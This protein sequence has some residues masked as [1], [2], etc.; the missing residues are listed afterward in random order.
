MNSINK[1]K[2]ESSIRN[3]FKNLSKMKELIQN[4]PSKLTNLASMLALFV[5]LAWTQTSTAQVNCNVTMACNDGVQ[6]SL[7]ENCLATI[8]PD[9]ILENPQFDMDDYAVLIYDEAGDLVP[10][11]TLDFSHV[12]Q[13]FSV[14]VQLIGCAAACWGNITLEDK[15]PPV[16]NDCEDI[17]VECGA[18]LEPGSP[19]VPFPNIV[20]ACDTN[21]DLVHFDEM[22]TNACA[23][24][25]VQTITRTWVATDGSGNE[26]TCVQL[27]QVMKADIGN[28]VFPPNFDDVDQPSFSCGT[29]IELLDNGAPSP[30]V[31][32]FPSGA[33]CP[34]IQ[35]F[36]EDIIFDICGASIKILRAWVVIDWCTGEERLENQII[37]I[38]DDQ[39]PV[40]TAA[41][42]F[43]FEIPTDQGL[44][45]GTFEVPAPTV[46]FE[47]SD[48][49]YTVGYRLRADGD[50]PFTDLLFDNITRDSGTGLFT[51]TGLPQDTSWIVYTLTDACGNVSQCF[52][53]VFIQDDESPTPV[54]EGF[55]VV[56]LE[57][58]GWADIFAS[59]IDDGSFDNC[60]I[61]RFEVRRLSTPCGISSDLNFGDRVNFCC[62][63]VADGPV[64]VV[65]RVYDVAGN[66]NDCIV[67]VTVQDKIDP[68][69]S[70]PPN[71]SLQC[72]ADFTNLDLTGRATATDNCNVTLEYTDTENINECGLGS[73]S[74]RWVATDP[75]G[76]SVNCTQIITLVDNDPFGM[77][78]ITFPGDRTIN[79]CD[80]A[81]ASPD[82]IN[83][84]P[85]L[86]NEDCANIAVSYDD[87]V[88]YG[89]ED[90]C[91]KI[92]RHWR[93]IDWCN[94]DPQNP[95]VFER[96]QTIQLNNN[97]DPVFASCENINVEINECEYTLNLDVMATDDCTPTS[98]LDFSYAL[99]LGNDGS[100]DIFGNGNTTTRTLSAG[101]H[102]IDWTVVDACGNEA[103]CTQLITITSTR[104]P[105]P[106]CLG[107]V[108]WVLGHDG[109]AEVWAS[110]FDLKS[111]AA[112]GSDDDLIFSFNSA[113]T[114]P[115]MTFTCA[116]IPN[117]IA[118]EISL[119][120]YVIDGSGNYEFCDVTL[121][122]QDS[123]ASNVCTDMAGMRPTVAGKINNIDNEGIL[124]IEVELMDILDQEASMNMT[125]SEGVY[126]FGD[127]DFYGAYEIEPFKNDDVTNGV[128]TLDLVLIQR[129][130]LGLEL[131]E[132]PYLVIA[133]D[134]DAN[135][136][137]SS[138]DLLNLRKVILGITSDF[139]DNTSWR[140][141]P[142]TFEFEDETSPFG[143]PE[144]V[145]FQEVLL[146]DE[147]VD[148]TAIKVGDINGNATNGLKSEVST[149]RSGNKAI[150][151]ESVPFQAA[152]KVSIPVMVDDIDELIGFQFSMQI[153]S[154]LK[155]ESINSGAL[156]MQSSNYTINGNEV[157]ISWNDVNATPVSNKE[158]L[159]TI[160][161]VAVSDGELDVDV[162]DSYNAEIYDASL[163]TYGLDIEIDSREE[164]VQVLGTQLYQNTP[165]PFKGMTSIG[166]DL[167]KSGLTTLS[168][169]DVAGK[170]LYRIS[171]V[172]PEGYNEISIDVASMGAN[173]GVLFYTLSSGEFI[174]T[175]KM[176]VL[177]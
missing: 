16:I 93:V 144:S 134:I 46:V 149:T 48:W 76:R 59:S 137:V 162:N 112:C 100:S 35:T 12:N 70:C 121:V 139:K 4:R 19:G 83:S 161:A 91:V 169:F 52:T 39:A 1:M 105:Q 164:S 84:R 128:S 173:S 17:I 27:V 85:I 41:P 37:K 3:R 101:T 106:I 154:N 177:D 168:I 15:L 140:F 72:T 7:D 55:T 31:T 9:M 156:E 142:A 54:C 116:D 86:M 65:L 11:N 21:L 170:E 13:D 78:D 171:N 58:A 133:A 51:I 25:F 148:F 44:C 64:Q 6:V 176:F 8:F 107:E 96:T 163:N 153:S 22:S 172:F 155:V 138:S 90:F 118:E 109:V 26:S 66:F 2:I 68:I 89:T 33:E 174:D 5:M 141:V 166:F 36:Y 38:I 147:D 18:N 124:D 115:N 60:E 24:D 50:D 102:S 103:M 110:D 81:D 23:A 145:Q 77:N 79:A 99:D 120:M 122:L 150:T 111:E 29:N 42:D 75:Q 43:Q 28:I 47:C 10:G 108:T 53:E 143:F 92:L 175:K 57:D 45:T 88:F 56:G 32:G 165:N 126:A 114:Q 129:H 157:I 98:L 73:V 49:D 80:V 160:E 152:D 62:E 123:G 82:A 135:D 146:S 127:V 131:I 130:I 74:R 125:D 14:N 67:N 69:I 104:R 158:V 71:I 159:F 136:R 30:N 87:N 132:N 119:Q 61:D 97:V 167:S 95:V 63:D 40:C 113:G 151:L 117:G 34:N 20:D 94:Y